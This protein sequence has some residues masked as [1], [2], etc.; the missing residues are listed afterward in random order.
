MIDSGGVSG[1]GE[2]DELGIVHVGCDLSSEGWP[3][4]VGVFVPPRD[5]C[6]SVEI[7]EPF[8]YEVSR[9]EAP[10]VRNCPEHRVGHET[11]PGSQ[12]GLKLDV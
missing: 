1:V 10:H 7:V 2:G 9:S 5:Q 11:K 4:E 3:V 12:R 6:G 8:L